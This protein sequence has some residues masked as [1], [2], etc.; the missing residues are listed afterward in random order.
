MSTL[1]SSI[2]YIRIDGTQKIDAVE[3]E[4]LEKLK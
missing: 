2:K 4:I 1:D 3:K